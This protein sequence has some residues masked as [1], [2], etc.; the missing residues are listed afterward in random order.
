MKPPFKR[1][2]RKYLRRE[3]KRFE[4]YSTWLS[5]KNEKNREDNPK[6]TVGGVYTFSSGKD[7]LEKAKIRDLSSRGVF[8]C[9]KCSSDLWAVVQRRL[10]FW[11]VGVVYCQKCGTPLDAPNYHGYLGYK[12]FKEHITN[13][14]H[15]E[16]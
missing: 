7:V 3:P 10:L 15:D 14:K 5:S 12:E 13:L 2:A 4:D 9:R 16:T 8:K 1:Q 11:V 6:P